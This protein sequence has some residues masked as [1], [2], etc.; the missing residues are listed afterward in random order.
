MTRYKALVKSYL[1]QKGVKYREPKDE[2][3]HVV[4]RGDKLNEIGII[5]DF[6]SEGNRAQFMCFSI[7]KY[8]QDQYAKGLIACNACNAKYRWVKFYLDNDNNTVVQADAILDEANCGEEVFELIQRMVGI[9]DETYP[10]F[11]KAHWS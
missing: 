5:I 4:Y 9:I 7:G 8:E 2:L 3:L 11:M 6:Q 10:V 1:D